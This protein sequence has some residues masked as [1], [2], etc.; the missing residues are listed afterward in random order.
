VASIQFYHLTTTPLERALPKLLERAVSGGYKV[1]LAV[2]SD[3]R[4]EQLNQLLW[5]YDPGSFL[6]HGS[7]RELQPEMQ[8]ILIST[9][10]DPV[11]SAN[12]LMVTD[13]R[14][15]KDVEFERIIDI[16][17]GNDGQITT[18]ARTRWKEYKDIGHELTYFSQN[19]QGGWQKK[20]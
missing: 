10:T 16:F 14:S 9:S 4:G 2:E 8:P 19:E 12:L 5:T 18:A 11:N 17:D 7:D 6:A 20:A 3:E 13:G 1:L 15:V